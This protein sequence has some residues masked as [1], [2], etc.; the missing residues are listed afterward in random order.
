ME[1]AALAPSGLTLLRPA[2]GA[3]A[4]ALAFLWR[5]AWASANPSV[6]EVAP[7]P[8]WLARVQAEFGP[9]RLAL[10]GERDGAIV[11]F[12]VLDVGGTHLHQLFV[13]PEVQGAGIGAALVAQ[14]CA[15]CPTGWSLHVAST[16][17][18]ARRFYA[19]C[20]L[21]EREHDIHPVTGRE[22][23]LCRWLPAARP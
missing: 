13:D 16:N 23:V 4:P 2:V 20:G 6:A 14:V 3:D 11:A 19:T 15:H 7:L 17:L 10:A 22:R 1:P 9:P 8:H 5:R 12:M 21:V 18:R